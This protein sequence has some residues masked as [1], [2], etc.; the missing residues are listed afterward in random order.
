M[1]RRPRRSVLLLAVAVWLPT[2]ALGVGLQAAARVMRKE[3]RRLEAATRALQH[4]TIPGAATPPAKEPETTPVAACRARL[5]AARAEVAREWPAFAAAALAS[6]EHPQFRE[7]EME[8]WADDES[9]ASF[10]VS[11]KISEDLLRDV[12]R[13]DWA[14]YRPLKGEPAKDKDE[15][16]RVV[17]AY[18]HWQGDITVD[19]AVTPTRVALVLK[20]FKRAIDDCA[21][22]VVEKPY[23]SLLGETPWVTE[24]KRPYRRIR[25]LSPEKMLPAITNLD[26]FYP[27]P[28]DVRLRHGTLPC[29]RPRVAV[30]AGAF[31]DAADVQRSLLE[32]RD[33]KLPFGY[34]VVATAT[35]LSLDEPEDTIAVVVGLFRNRAEASSWRRTHPGFTSVRVLARSGDKLSLLEIV[36]LTGP[37]HV[38]AYRLKDAI[39]LSE[40]DAG[41]PSRG[42]VAPVCQV[43]GDALFAFPSKA[44]EEAIFGPEGAPFP[45][46]DRVQLLPVRCDGKL[47]YVQR[48]TS[49]YEAVFWTDAAGTRRITQIT[50]VACGFT[51]FATTVV[52]R[53]GAHTVEHETSYVHDGC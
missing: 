32:L 5:E 1:E 26:S 17:S 4:A 52:D 36:R 2:L 46:Q 14:P 30:V 6:R 37:A 18:P 15:R 41:T 12:V 9:G 53:S 43:P 51:M 33:R 24:E 31:T 38:P 23:A 47:A 25:C 45:E 16:A 8:L 20:S 11:A 28:F 10:N 19:G 29:P 49:T 44:F 39:R 21:A 50:G 3:A 42:G 27:P 22:R 48:L 35:D 13:Q 34:P 40:R 7:V